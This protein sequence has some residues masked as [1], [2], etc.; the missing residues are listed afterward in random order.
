MEKLFKKLY[1]ALFIIMIIFGSNILINR[2]SQEN[3]NNIYQIGISENS[4]IN[5]NN[6]Q[7]EKLKEE[8]KNK[9]MTSIICENQSL[10]QIE[11][12]RD[13]KI[14]SVEKFLTQNEEDFEK[15]IPNDAIKDNIVINVNKDDFSKE[16]LNVINNYLDGYKV[17]DNKN[18]EIFYVD[19]QVMVRSNGQSIV[20]PIL[21]TPFF[22]NEKSVKDIVENKLNVVLAITNPSEEKVQNIILEQ[23]DYVAS[24]YGVKQVQLRGTSVLGYPNNIEKCFDSMINNNIT[25]FTTEFQ[26]STGLSTY[27]KLNDGN[28]NRAHE[29]SVDELKL[30]ENELAARISRAVKERNIR[31]INIKNFIDYKDDKSVESSIDSL[32]SSIKKS[33][34]QLKGT[35]EIGLV[36]P[37]PNMEKHYI[38]GIFIAIAFSALVAI[39]FLSIFESKYYISIIIFLLTAIGGIG[40]ISIDNMLLIKI[41]TFLI[42]IT[43]ACSAI[44][45]AYKSSY[46]SF[47]IKYI[48]SSLIALSTGI[49]IASTMYGTDYMLKLKVFSGVKILYVLPPIIIGIWIILSLN[50]TVFKNIKSVKDIQFMIEDKLR[51]I[52][53]YH[54]ILGLF[55][56]ACIYIY[57]N[58]SGNSGNA[59]ELELQIREFLERILYVRPR[60]KEFLIGYPS[61]L[62]SYYLCN[63]N[64]KNAEYILVIGAIGTMSTVN[65]FTHLHTPFLYSLLRST[66]GIVFGAIIG[67]IYILIFNFAIKYLNKIKKEK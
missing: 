5:M 2:V 60:T 48:I 11:K 16:E 22:I 38:S 36:N 27:S 6:K 47:I 13:L 58:R 18:L 62:I 3:N 42:A 59:G 63:K 24:K 23:I 65:T 12:Y 28:I 7:L 19:S 31:F 20:N 67:G 64:Y 15:I 30:N 50:Y 45:I 26:T 8:T 9:G 44:I 14:E 57:I 1:I 61:L 39:T 34:E 41:D 49:I 46:K 54:I 40:V 29:I 33:Q 55:V 35:F 53:V 4:I 66:Y 17:I 10:S 32:F 37:V 56:I 43:G 51:S 25:I 21:T 52:K